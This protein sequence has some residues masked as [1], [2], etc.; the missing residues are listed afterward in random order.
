MT[1]AGTRRILRPYAALF[2][3]VIHGKIES[4]WKI[5]AFVG[6]SERRAAISSVP[7]VACSRPAR[8]RRSVVFPHPLGPTIMKN[9]PDWMSTDTLSMAVSAPNVLVRLRMRIAAKDASCGLPPQGCSAARFK[10]LLSCHIGECVEAYQNSC[11][12]ASAV[13]PAGLVRE[14]DRRERAQGRPRQTGGEERRGT[15]LPA[16]WLYD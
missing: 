16:Q 12:R 10:I 9:S 15:K 5:I 1:A 13:H 11:N 4:P 8:M 2:H 6:R 14:Q 7:A 3:T